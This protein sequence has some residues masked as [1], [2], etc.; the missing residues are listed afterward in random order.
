MRVGVE[1]LGSRPGDALSIGEVARTAG[2]SKGLL[3]HYFRDKEQF[4]IAVV[5]AAGAEL[6]TA[7]E[8]DPSLPPVKRVESAI[9]GLITFA[10]NHAAGYIAMLRGDL[11]LAGIADAIHRLRERR[12]ASFVEQIAEVSTV[13]PELVRGCQTLKIVLDGQLTFL[14]MSVMHWL[15][16]QDIDREKL[17]RLLVRSFFMALV[18]VATV[19]PDLRL[20]HIVRLEDVVA[21]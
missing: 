10:E 21:A 7:T 11:A 20:H 14:E 2:V 18:A 1:L 6:I 19:E 16:H 13:D 12:V 8:P 17:L 3:Y 4:F 9:D 5:H 15:E